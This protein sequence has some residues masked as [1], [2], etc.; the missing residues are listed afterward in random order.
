MIGAIERM[1]QVSPAE[2]ESCAV[3][4]IPDD[5]YFAGVVASESPDRPLSPKPTPQRRIDVLV[6]HPGKV[7]LYLEKP[8]VRGSWHIIP[9]ERTQVTSVLYFGRGTSVRGLEPSIP[10]QQ[11]GGK[12]NGANCY[13]FNPSGYTSFGGPAVLALDEG[14]RALAGRGLNS[15]LRQTNDGSW[16]PANDSPDDPGV[17]LVVE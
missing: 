17:T 16:P 3:L 2:K 4:R 11:I 12:S 15:L 13:H 14:L 6:K 9:S 1:K 8:D 10:V 5:T 7:A